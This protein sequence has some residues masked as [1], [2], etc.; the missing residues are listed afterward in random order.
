MEWFT[1]EFWSRE[2]SVGVVAF[3][4]LTLIFG[5]LLL[6]GLIIFNRLLK[7]VL[8]G[9]VF[10]RMS[11]DTGVAHALATLLGYVI[12]VLGMLLILPV[13]FPG[14]EFTTLSVM[15][16]AVSFGIGF[17]L[18]NIADN[19]VS[20]LIIL[21]ERPIKVG[22]RI[23]VGDLTGDVI[24][25]RARSTSV[26]TND[27]THIIVPNS[28]FIAQQVV[29]WSHTDKLVRFRFPIGVHYNSDVP[30]VKKAIEA[31]GLAS[32]NVRRNPAPSAKFMG[33]GDS[34][35][36]FELWV[37]TDTR[38]HSPSS[39]HSEMNYLLWDALKAAKI[40]I[41]YPQRDLYIKELPAQAKSVSPEVDDPQPVERQ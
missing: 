2:F 5:T 15:V 24:A 20:G 19:F 7:K 41:P 8:T 37:W 34:S 36:D 22:D 16:G 14:F 11:L 32:P 38:S 1:W 31:A 3:T 27:N 12:L 40:E 29:N 10:P 9:R 21:L 33:F 26:R 4:P 28:Q 18:R 39:F 17:G 35:L 13:T 6:V 25:I 30:T 23:A